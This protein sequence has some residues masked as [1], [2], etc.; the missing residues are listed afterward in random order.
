MVRLLRSKTWDCSQAP[1]TT[2]TTPVRVPATKGHG[3]SRT[4][5]AAQ[6]VS[7]EG[8]WVATRVCTGG[9]LLTRA[10]HCVWT[11]CLGGCVRWGT[12]TTHGVV[13]SAEAGAT[14]AVHLPAAG[15]T[16]GPRISCFVRVCSSAVCWS[17]GT[18]TLPRPRHGAEPCVHR[19]HPPVMEE[20]VRVA[21]VHPAG[22]RV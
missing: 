6:D 10:R 19:S 21:P 16:C 11:E 1:S 2:K 5:G 4:R 8:T 15:S 9:S 14:H 13:G 18:Q 7:S 22:S 20:A 12:F 3:G 17:R